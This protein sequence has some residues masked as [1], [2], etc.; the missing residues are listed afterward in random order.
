M[1]VAEVGSATATGFMAGGPW[2]A[3]ALGGIA[4]VSSLFGGKKATYQP[5][6]EWLGMREDVMRGI[7]RGIEE[8]GYTWSE[9]MGDTMFR[10]ASESIATRFEGAER[11]VLEATVPY[12]AVGAAGRGVSA[13]NIAEAQ[14]T[15]RAGRELDIARESTKL[16]SYS[17]LLQ[18]G[19]SI[20]DPNLPQ[21]QLD[22][23]N[24]AGAPSVGGAIETGLATGL[25]IYSA[26]KDK[27][28]WQNFLLQKQGRKPADLSVPSFKAGSLV[29]LVN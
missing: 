21:A 3:I 14:E 24:A 11:K 6:P 22:A 9:E 8:G 17:N 28:F 23:Y 29:D 12:G 4:A 1:G 15:A 27:D 7:R 26:Q 25:N 2:G 13:V 10:H 20:Q 19:G 18:M 5:N 16:Q